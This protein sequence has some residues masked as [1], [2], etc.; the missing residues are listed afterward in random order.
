M[1]LAPRQARRGRGGV[2]QMGPR[3]RGRSGATT[4]TLRFVIKHGG[5]V[6]A[7]LPIKELGDEAPLYDRPACPG[8]DACPMLDPAAVAAADVER[9][10]RCCALLG[11]PD[12]C[13]KRWVWEQYDHLIRGN[14]VAGPGRRRRG[15]AGRRRAEGA[16]ADDRRH[17]AL[18]RGRSGRGRQ[19]GG[20][21]GLAQPHRGRAPCRWRSP[22]TSTSA[23]P[24]S[25]RPW[26]N[27][28][29]A[30]A[31]SARRRGRSIS[32]SCRATCRST[33]RR[34]GSG[35]LPTPTIGGVGLVDG[36]RA[37][38][39][40]RAS[41]AAGEAI[42][43][44]GDTTGWLGQSRL[45]AR[46]L[47]PRGRRAAAGRSRGRAAQRRFRPR[48]RSQAG[49]VT[50]CTISPTAAWRWRWPRWRWPSGIGATHRAPDRARRRPHGAVCSAR[51]RAR[52]LLTV[53]GGRGAKR[54]IDAAA[55]G[56]RAGRVESAR[57]A[58]T[59]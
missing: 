20:G 36:R 52:Y 4:D 41:S 37:D 35:I 47:R 18:L 54:C 43:L 59:R 40:R 39:Q 28:S 31:A 19:A 38:R 12:L 23:I 46:H 34:A 16:G 17:A 26:A 13:S 33:T 7:D 25:P 21:G 5:V 30:S 55:G 29:A 48:P 32:R 44:V 8:A 2:P 14:T 58:A 22:T 11:S 49:R 57:P 10:R 15:R 1:V 51:T 3:F 42:L 24:K 50:R 53:A 6:K 56:G 27:S 9:A 45:P